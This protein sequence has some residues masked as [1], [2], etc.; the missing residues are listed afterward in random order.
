MHSCYSFQLVFCKVLKKV[1]KDKIIYLLWWACHLN[2]VFL[3]YVIRIVWLFWKNWELCF[4]YCE[5]FVLKEY[6]SLNEC[7][8][9]GEGFFVIGER[10]S[11]C[12]RKLLWKNE[13]F[14]WWKVLLW[15]VKKCEKW[16]RRLFKL[17]LR[18]SFF[19]FN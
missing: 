1:K 9:V 7:F 5:F 12:W 16:P 8:V 6:L 2:C 13:G 3:R 14:S 18:Y 11:W 15:F 10:F 17:F 19:L 4:E